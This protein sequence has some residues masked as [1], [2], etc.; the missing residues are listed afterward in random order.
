M[1]RL[2][3]RANRRGTSASFWRGVRRADTSIAFGTME[4]T[5]NHQMMGEGKGRKQIFVESTFG[6]KKRNNGNGGAS[7]AAFALST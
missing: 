1:S 7:G 2:G 3:S 6:P 4:R 5:V